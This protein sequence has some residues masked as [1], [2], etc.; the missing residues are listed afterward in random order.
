MRMRNIQ[1][2]LSVNMQKHTV[3][4]VRYL[5]YCAIVFKFK[6]NKKTPC[7]TTSIFLINQIKFVIV[8]IGF[9]Q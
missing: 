3:G 5:I 9:V 4:L 7:I 8:R 2:A 6:K 1:P